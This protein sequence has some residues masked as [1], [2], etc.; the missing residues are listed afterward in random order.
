MYV[1]LDF[2]FVVVYNLHM[3]ETRGILMYN[4]KIKNEYLSSLPAATAKSQRSYF[5]KIEPYEEKMQKDIVFFSKAEFAEMMRN[6][7]GLSLGNSLYN[8]P[9][10]MKRY[11]RW[12]SENYTP[13]NFEYV[14][15]VDYLKILPLY[16]KSSIELLE[17]I[18]LVVRDK[19]TEC[20]IPF[21]VVAGYIKE[22]RMKD[23]VA[24][25]VILLSWCGLSVKEI[26]NL[27]SENVFKEEKCIYV[28]SRKTLIAVDDPV[29]HVLAQI[30][31]GNSYAKIEK[32]TNDSKQQNDNILTT[33]NF[34]YTE[35]FLKKRGKSADYANPVSTK[36]VDLSLGEF[37][38]NSKGK[39]FSLISLRENGMFCRAYKKSKT[40]PEL[41]FKKGK[42]DE[43]YYAI[44]DNWVKDISKNKFKE[45]KYKYK[46]FV[47]LFEKTVE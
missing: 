3:M 1:C 38:R 40:M 9:S 47:K 33:E 41:Q 44:F 19:A 12:Y 46:A 14:F 27:K 37:N 42:D 29:I 15:T 8:L 10:S 17:D 26:I 4:E 35:F 31:A 2:F 21:D 13:V 23:N 43:D 34:Q 30:K 20:G 32:N 5:S 28:E 7:K 39:V 24:I 18:D 45:L 11:G 6:I 22:L 36:L 16:Y 25:G